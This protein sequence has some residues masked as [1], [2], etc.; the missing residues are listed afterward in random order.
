MR[1]GIGPLTLSKVGQDFDLGGITVSNFQPQYILF[2][3]LKVIRNGAPDPSGWSYQY[4]VY[5]LYNSIDISQFIDMALS[6][7]LPPMTATLDNPLEAANITVTAPCYVVM[8]LTS[9]DST[10]RFRDNH[11]AIKTSDDHR[12]QYRRLSHVD[13]DGNVHVGTSTTNCSL[14]YFAVKSIALTDQ[15]HGYNIYVQYTDDGVVMPK[16]IDPAI[17]NRGGDDASSGLVQR[18]AGKQPKA[19]PSVAAAHGAATNGAAPAA[20]RQV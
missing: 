8:Q 4:P 15:D 14:I 11:E 10:M 2:Y 9:D 18:K 13:A 17:K 16:A 7:D 6:D 12:T 3:R 5:G 19:A 1:K 20:P